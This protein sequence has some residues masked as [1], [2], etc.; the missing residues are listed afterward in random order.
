M[1]EGRDEA[2]IMRGGGDDV[3]HLVGGPFVVSCTR[4]APDDKT[5]T[6]NADASN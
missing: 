6:D 1:P 5:K 3:D 2:S 4:R